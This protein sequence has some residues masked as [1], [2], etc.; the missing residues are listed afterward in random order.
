MLIE[1]PG[2]GTPIYKLEYARTARVWFLPFLL[3]FPTFWTSEIVSF[4]IKDFNGYFFLAVVL[5]RVYFFRI[6]VL[7]RVWILARNV[8]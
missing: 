2:G 5:Q 8:Y 1:P 6:L 4:Y 3:T 7:E